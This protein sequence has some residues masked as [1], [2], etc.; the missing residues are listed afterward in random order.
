MMQPGGRQVRRQPRVVRW[1]TII[2]AIAMLIT[3]VGAFVQ[4]S[5]G[6]AQPLSVSLAG[7]RA[8]TTVPAPGTVVLPCAAGGTTDAPCVCRSAS[9]RPA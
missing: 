5:E 3:A 2:V 7:D 1:L 6:T 9:S 4:P 8:E